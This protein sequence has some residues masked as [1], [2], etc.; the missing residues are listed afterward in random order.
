MATESSEPPKFPFARPENSYDAPEQTKRLRDNGP[1]SRVQL[2]DGALAWIV[3]KHKEV[4]EMLSSEKLSNVR[5][6][7]HAV[8]TPRAD[9]QI[10]RI[11]TV[12]MATQN[13]IQQAE[14][15]M[16]SRRLCKW[17]IPNTPSRGTLDWNI[18]REC[19]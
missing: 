5:P 8:C 11:V 17:I 16:Q 4:C 19:K 6:K 18:G 1:V 15:Q 12:V 3:G 14:S 7:E 10:T 2:F 9:F 13:Y